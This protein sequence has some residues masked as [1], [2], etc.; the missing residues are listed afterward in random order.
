MIMFMIFMGKCK[1]NIDYF[2]CNKLNVLFYLYVLCMVLY[3]FNKNILSYGNIFK[4]CDVLFFVFEIF[5]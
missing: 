3:C 1:N 4:E 2:F 5:L